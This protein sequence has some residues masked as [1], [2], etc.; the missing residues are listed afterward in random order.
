MKI[1]LFNF[2][3]LASTS[4]L[5]TSLCY[6]SGVSLTGALKAPAASA[7]SSSTIPYPAPN[8]LLWAQTPLTTLLTPLPAN[9]P[10]ASASSSSTIPYPA[11]NPLLWLQTPLTPPLTPLPTPSDS[12]SSS[13]WPL[14]LSP[15]P[16]GSLEPSTADSSGT[17]S[18][19]SASA[20]SSLTGSLVYPYPP[21]PTMSSGASAASLPFPLPLPRFTSPSPSSASADAAKPLTKEER[22]EKK[23]N[24]KKL[25]AEIK[26]RARKLPI[27]S[28]VARINAG[29]DPETV[30]EENNQDPIALCHGVINYIQ[31]LEKKGE[32]VSKELSA[33][34]RLCIHNQPEGNN[35]ESSSDEEEGSDTEYVPS[36]AS[37][38]SAA[39]ASASSSSH[40]RK[41]PAK[42]T[43]KKRKR[44]AKVTREQEDEAARL[45]YNGLEDLDLIRSKLNNM[46]VWGGLTDCLERII[47]RVSLENPK[48]AK[49]KIEK[50]KNVLKKAR[51]EG[52]PQ[53]N[54]KKDV[55][56]SASSSSSTSSS[57][58]SAASAC[59][60]SLSL[61]SQ[62]IK[63]AQIT[64]EKKQE[65]IHKI[66]RGEFT[67]IDQVQAAWD[68][69]S[70]G[71]IA[72]NLNE[73]IKANKSIDNGSLSNL[74]E[75]R[76]LAY[77]ADYN[78]REKVKKRPSKAQ[79]GNPSELLPP[80][81]IYPS[82][83]ASAASSSVSSSSS[84]GSGGRTKR[85]ADASGNA[86]QGLAS[87]SPAAPPS[88]TPVS[89][90]ADDQP[91]QKKQK[92]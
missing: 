63:R 61:S 66:M 76:R 73:Y 43:T 58:A 49:K 36:S 12:S 72:K 51:K 46:K 53:G 62:A 44:Q 35:S 14:P 79:F 60:I 68:N 70:P 4:T 74:E 2:A 88:A 19:A 41:D 20:S 47:K 38:A 16:L 90:G 69:M 13:Y 15:M 18:A 22:K 83:S 37:S 77:L 54:I 33:F 39:S 7:S 1:I 30:Y 31:G 55:K 21:V 29:E 52:R 24:L 87:A 81:N 64:K 32:E 45:I 84:S 92:T 9:A 71:S 91:S 80:L 42:P 86:N 59:A 3:L 78:A 50:L 89:A 27:K 10:A 28:I 17:P 75:M 67:T 6:G 85:K 57:S 82:P 11:P 40:P 5:L 56:A 25:L 8:P 48:D 23:E 34:D 26:V 65:G